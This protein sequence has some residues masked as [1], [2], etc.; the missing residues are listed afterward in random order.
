MKA[1]TPNNASKSTRPNIA[2]VVSEYVELRRNGKELMGLC[3]FHSEKHPSFTVNEEKDVF[4]CFGCGAGGDVIRFVELIKGLTFKE[5][6]KLLNLETY[7]PRQRPYRD[8]AKRVVTWARAVSNCLRDILRDIGD[9]VY[10]CSI[11]RKEP[12]AD[13]YLIAGHEAALIRQ[14]VILSDLDDDLNQPET[15]LNLWEQRKDIG[16]LLESIS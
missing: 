13:L 10:T 3:P 16:R 8:Q 14:W 9:Q 1:N 2:Q 5:A 12:L 7:R 6:L 15:A 4:H 11:A